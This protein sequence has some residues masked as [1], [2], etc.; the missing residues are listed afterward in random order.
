[1]E[2]AVFM[3]DYLNIT[4][5]ANSSFSHKGDKAI[6]IA[7][8]DSG[9]DS[10]KAPFTGII[11]KIYI[12]DNTV[13]LESVDKVKYADGTID[14]MTIFTTH[15]ND[16]SNLKVGDIIKQGEIYYHEGTRG[17]ATGNHIHLA[18]GKGKFTGNGWYQNEY[19]YWVIN[20]Q[21]DVYKAL[22][23]LDSVNVINS[24][25]YNW[26]KTSTLV[27]IET[28]SNLKIYIV[29]RG[30]NLSTIAKTYNTT[31]SEL[32]RI[33]NIANPNLIYVGQKI[34]LP[35][36][37]IYFKKYNDNSLS[38]VDALKSIGEKS[39]YDYRTKIAKNNGIQNYVGT[40]VQNTELL[41]LLKDGKLIKP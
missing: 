5:N 3:M 1:M 38:L 2:K 40:G 18:I 37:I 7:G 39:D 20:N 8:K 34:K 22:Y 24:G 29:K 27:D 30:D 13:W 12:N 33:N 36:N 23:L 4:Q 9:I 25:G 26:V 15:D 32:V 10:F 6:D 16:I 14:Y 35:T 17:Y 31:I 28:T 11:K 19:G 41:K 21:Y